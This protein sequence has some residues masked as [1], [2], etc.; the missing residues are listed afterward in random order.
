MRSAL[1]LLGTPAVVKADGSWGGDGVAIVRTEDEALAAFRRFAKPPSRLRS[2]FRAAKRRDPHHLTMAFSPRGAQVCLQRFVPGSLAASAFAAWGGKIAASFHYDI[3]VADKVIGPPNVIKRIDCSQMAFATQV[4]AREFGLTGLHGI[5]Y[6]RDT[7]GDIYVLEVNPR[8]THGGALP[9]GEGRDLPAGLAGALTGKST[10]MRPPIDR[11][12][13]ALFPREWRRDPSS[14]YLK[15]GFHD[16]P[17]DDP[18]VLRRELQQLGIGSIDEALAKL[19][20]ARMND[21]APIRKTG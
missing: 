6:I 4:T 2:L 12:I 14:E 9:F 19:G 10:G 18:E 7:K 20:N 1:R 16:V 5:D 8:A 13:V 3:L 11:D 21:K 15:I 17:W